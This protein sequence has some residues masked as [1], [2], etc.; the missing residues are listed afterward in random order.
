MIK[1]ITL[2][3]FS[4]TVTSK[5]AKT[6]TILSSSTQQVLQQHL[7]WKF[8]ITDYTIATIC[9]QDQSR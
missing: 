9:C 3:N 7:L 4:Y 5:K 2:I 6:I 1:Q 8:N